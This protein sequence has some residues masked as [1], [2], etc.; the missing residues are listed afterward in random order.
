MPGS[1][2]NPGGSPRVFISYARKDGEEYAR[3]LHTRLEEE[4]I[5]CWMDRFGMEGGKDWRQ[6]ILEAID[7]VE[8]L[9]LV[10]TPAAI[11]SPN[12]QWE[13]RSARQQGV[14]IYPVKAAPKLDYSSLPRWMNKVHWYTLEHEWTKFVN[15]LNTRC[16][17]IR[18]PFMVKDLPADFVERP[19]EFEQLISRLLDEKREE[20]VAITAALQGA[21][22][23]GK[24]TIAKALCHNERVQEAFDDGILWVTLGENPGNLVG[25]IEDLIYMLSR[26]QHNFTGLDAATARFA[27]LLA[28]RDILLVIDDVW[29][30]TDLKPFLQGGKKRCARLITTRNDTVLPADAQRIPVDAMQS[31]EAVQLLGVGLDGSGGSGRSANE[32]QAL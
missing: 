8:F 29:N 12:V 9:V 28:D 22:G 20:P 10:M 32:I 23:Y 24:T 14:C 17:Q 18:V 3:K 27:E 26:E 7:T 25:K 31:D 13:W 5:P 21:G 30:A 6:Q 11:Q 19:K 15:D 1:S 2:H 4:A 16:Q